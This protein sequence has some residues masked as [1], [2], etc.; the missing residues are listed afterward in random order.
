MMNL[1]VDKIYICGDGRV[2]LIA[3]VLKTGVSKGTLGSN[4]SR[5]AKFRWNKYAFNSTISLNVYC[6]KKQPSFLINGV[7]VQ[8]VRMLACHARG[9]G[10]DPPRRRQIKDTYS[11]F[12]ANGMIVP[13]L[14]VR[15]QLCQPKALDGEMADSS[16]GRARVIASVLFIWGYS[17]VWLERLPCKQEVRSST[18]LTSTTEVM[19]IICSLRSS[20]C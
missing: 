17:S 13:L 10:F 14:L 18:L 12:F 1:S 6:M 4:P 5:R 15:V 20:I 7:V 16:I 8:L 3:P 19:R 11:K 2:W 9:Q